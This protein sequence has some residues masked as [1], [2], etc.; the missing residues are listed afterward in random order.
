MFDYLEQTLISFSDKIPVEFFAFFASIIEEIVAPI[1][2]PAVMI[3]T[4]SIA[5]AREL[6]LGYLLILVVLGASGKLTGSLIVY[7][8]SDKVEDRLSGVI[9][10]FFG[11]KHEDIESFGEKFSGG[12]RD[13]MTL[14]LLRALPFVPSALVSIGSGILKIPIKIFIISTF[15]GSLVRDFI[16]M[17]F[18][19][20]GIS[21]LGDIIHNS[22]SIESLV[23]MIV[24]LLI[25]AGLAFMYYKKR[26]K[27]SLTS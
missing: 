22:E 8:I 21:I 27:G 7:Y 20:A 15:I 23:Q 16:Y 12:W 26:K 2:S 11:V 17:Y 9:E 19:Y 13:Y 5:S 1:P 6:S 3:V 25:F 24:L 18:G 14:S 4:G 10:K